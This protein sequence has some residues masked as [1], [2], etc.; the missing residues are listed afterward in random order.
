[1]LRFLSEWEDFGVNGYDN[2][3]FPVRKVV[4]SFQES[5]G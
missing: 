1:M 4:Q 2:I 5:A 3:M